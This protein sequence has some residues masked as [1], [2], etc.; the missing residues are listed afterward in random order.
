MTHYE[1]IKPLDEDF[2]DFAVLQ[3][4]LIDFNY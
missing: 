3:K 1:N 2:N 4:T